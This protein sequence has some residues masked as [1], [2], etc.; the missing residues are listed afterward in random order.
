MSELRILVTGGTRGI[1]AAI[2][3][4]LQSHQLYVGGRDRAAVEQACSLYPKAAPFVC[5]LRDP[6]SIAQA[7]KQV[8]T[9]DVLVLNA[10]IAS[11]GN[12]SEL[13]HEQWQD[14]LTVNVV[15]QADLLRHLLPQ[16]RRSHGLV[17]A[18]NSGAG[19]RASAGSAAYSASKF[20]LRAL[21]DALR[22]E[23]RGR[24]RVTSVHPGR[25]DTDMQRQI[26][27]HHARPYRGSDHLP[28]EAIAQ[29]V[30]TAVQMPPQAV[31]ESISVRPAAG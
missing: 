3:R 7:C 29:A 19:Y 16:L 2:C 27:A 21:T 5:D 15:A 20:A 28:A 26:Q 23:E 14:I 8:E 4:H 9:L 12:V 1:G 6:A 25:V 18:I 11:P 30:A 24:V 22:E 31:V 10:G 13:T 17:V